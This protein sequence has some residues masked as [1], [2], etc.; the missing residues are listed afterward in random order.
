MAK[1]LYQLLSRIRAPNGKIILLVY[2]CVIVDWLGLL[3]GVP[4]W[5]CVWTQSDGFFS[6]RRLTSSTA[7]A[8]FLC[9]SF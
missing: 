8:A 5:R 1:M 7:T 4:W 6:C 9:A 3:P 2:N